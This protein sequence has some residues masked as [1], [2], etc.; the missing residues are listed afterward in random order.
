MKFM[1]APR[2]NAGLL[3]LRVGIAISF[4]LLYA[5]PQSQSAEVFSYNPGRYW[6]LVALSF[7]AALVSLG[8]ATR[9]LSA[10]LALSWA[11]AAYI[12]LE[13]GQRWGA[14]PV[15]AT[16]FLILFATL[17]LTGAGKFS[18]DNWLRRYPRVQRHLAE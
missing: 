9:L 7:G 2:I 5:L 1:V 8:V 6:P 17:A 16:L 10:C 13:A 15:R 3:T 4:I 18:V 11:W 12:E 14:L